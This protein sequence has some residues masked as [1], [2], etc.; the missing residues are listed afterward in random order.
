[1]TKSS[2]SEHRANKFKKNILAISLEKWLT[3]TNFELKRIKFILPCS[4]YWA[5]KYKAFGVFVENNI[6]NKENLFS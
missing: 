2:I 3:N 6:R 4:L 5:N 1:M